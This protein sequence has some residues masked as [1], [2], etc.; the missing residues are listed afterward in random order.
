MPVISTTAVSGR[1]AGRDR[2]RPRPRSTSPSSAISL[3]IALSAMRSPPEM[4]KARA[5]SRLPT[6]VGLSRMNSR[7][8]C[9]VGSPGFFFFLRSLMARRL[10]GFSPDTSRRVGAPPSRRRLELHLDEGELVVVGVDDV[11]LDADGPV[12]GSS[13][14][15]LGQAVLLAVEQLQLP[16]R[17]GHDHVVVGVAMPARLGARR[18]APFR[19]LHPLVVDLNG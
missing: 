4:P 8:C 18:E 16:A 7:T 9:F 12:V 14:D 3:S 17:H 13:G 19:H 11:V 15:E 10:G 2:R 6:G 1:A 5:I